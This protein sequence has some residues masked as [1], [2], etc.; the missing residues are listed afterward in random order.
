MD[1]GRIVGRL[2]HHCKHLVE[3]ILEAADRR[4]VAAA[5]IAIFEQERG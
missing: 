2:V 4:T 5:S 3:N 1:R